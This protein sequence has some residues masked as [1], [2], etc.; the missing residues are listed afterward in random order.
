MKR[1]GRTFGSFKSVYC[2]DRGVL[3]N[4]RARHQIQLLLYWQIWFDIPQ[5]GVWTLLGFLCLCIRPG[6]EWLRLPVSRG[7]ANIRRSV[8]T[9]I[10]PSTCIST[11]CKGVLGSWIRSGYGRLWLLEGCYIYNMGHSTLH[12]EILLLTDGQW[13]AMTRLI[14]KIIWEH[15]GCGG[16]HPVQFGLIRFYHWQSS[17]VIRAKWKSGSHS[18]SRTFDCSFLSFFVVYLAQDQNVCCSL[19][20]GIASPAV[21]SS[22]L[23]ASVSLLGLELFE[24]K[25]MPT[26]FADIPQ[27]SSKSLLDL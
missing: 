24:L 25:H 22:K 9:H 26:S 21:R 12:L 3:Y 6:L 15:L 1:V 27:R 2:H 19:N 10:R 18:V 23:E 5:E 17:G 14:A 13:M 4:H 7:W 16:C 20:F 11:A 8:L